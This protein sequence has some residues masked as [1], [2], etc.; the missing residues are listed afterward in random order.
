MSMISPM[1]SRLEHRESASSN[2]AL[3]LSGTGQKRHRNRT[4]FVIMWY[5]LWFSYNLREQYLRID[6]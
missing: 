3:S 4:S 1:R 2:M 5:P 6:Q